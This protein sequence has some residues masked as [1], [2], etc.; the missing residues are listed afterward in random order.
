MSLDVKPLAAFRRRPRGR[1]E[2]SRTRELGAL[3]DGPDQGRSVAGDPGDL[4]LAVLDPQLD[5]VGVV[6]KRLRKRIE[7]DDA[8]WGLMLLAPER[9]GRLF[10]GPTMPAPQPHAAR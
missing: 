3:L 7:D 9:G 1:R 5:E 6:G 2:E 4:Q 10:R 8:R